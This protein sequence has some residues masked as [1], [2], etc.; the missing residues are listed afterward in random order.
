[1]RSGLGVNQLCVDLHCRAGSP[2]A[3]LQKKADAAFATNLPCIDRL[4][5]VSQSGCARNDEG[6]WQAREVGGEIVR[7]SVREVVVLSVA[8][9]IAEG[10]DESSSPARRFRDRPQQRNR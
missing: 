6:A 4:A 5:L 2:Y 8:A 7:D 9:E 1:M 10:Q 3:P